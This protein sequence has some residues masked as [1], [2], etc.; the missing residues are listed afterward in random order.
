MAKATVDHNFDAASVNDE[1]RDNGNSIN[2]IVSDLQQNHRSYL[3]VQ[4]YPKC[5]IEEGIPDEKK[6]SSGDVAQ[7]GISPHK[8]A[9]LLTVLL[10]N[11][12]CHSLQVN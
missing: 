3:Q 9:G 8:D 2:N 6:E 11:D 10:Q 4:Y 12:G 7:L 1:E 5:N